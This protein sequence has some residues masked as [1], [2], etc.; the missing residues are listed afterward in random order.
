[1]TTDNYLERALG[2][3][4][5]QAI[6]SAKLA[7]A[8]VR[9]EATLTNNLNSSRVYLEYNNEMIS[10]FKD[11]LRTMAA[12]AYNATGGHSPETAACLEKSGEHFVSEMTQ[13]A[14][15]NAS[16]ARAFGPQDPLLDNLTNSLN[17]A[18]DAAVDDFIHGMLGGTPLKKDPLVNVVSNIT[19]SPGAVQQTALGNHNRQSVQQQ[20]ATVLRAIDDLL[21]SEE[22]KNLGDQERTRVQDVA[23]VLRD[24]MAKPGADP[25]KV[26]RW[27][28]TLFGLAKEFGMHIAAAAFAKVALTALSVPF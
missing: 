5:D 25:S 15:T 19:N 16:N 21:A 20:S 14:A 1:M 22:F 3:M 6:E 2:R 28:Q 11:V 26:R 12:F 13:W 9:R 17:E 7:V 18:K 10:V 23:D 8:K 4:T 27:A 24:E